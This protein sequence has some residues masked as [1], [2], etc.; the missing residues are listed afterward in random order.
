MKKKTEGEC[1][2]ETY[3]NITWH[4][5]DNLKILGEDTGHGSFLKTVVEA[6]NC[7]CKL[8]TLLTLCLKFSI[9]KQTPQSCNS[10]MQMG[11]KSLMQRLELRFINMFNEEAERW[12]KEKKK[13]TPSIN[14]AAQH[15]DK[16][17]NKAGACFTLLCFGFDYFPCWRDMTSEQWSLSNQ[18]RHPIISRGNHTFTP[19]T[20][21]G[22]SVFMLKEVLR[23][24]GGEVQGAFFGTE[25]LIHTDT[26][27]RKTDH[28]SWLSFNITCMNTHT[29]IH[30]V[31]VTTYPTA[32]TKESV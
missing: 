25:V 8:Q 5:I 31:P 9:I 13:K 20:P 30:T 15:C 22:Y 14:A 32:Q 24:G 18:T 10:S 21:R 12:K 26:W 28:V 4:P 1:D 29:H 16:A 19:K 11:H 3:N 27:E 2:V 6:E 7:F 17:G 23:R